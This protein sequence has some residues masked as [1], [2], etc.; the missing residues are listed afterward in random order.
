MG[1]AY[2]IGVDLGTTATKAA[3][4]QADGTLV[5]EALAEVPLYYPQ[6][7]CVE[8]DNDDFYRSAAYTVRQCM[9]NSGIAPSEVA[10][11]ALNSQMAGI[12][13]IDENF[14]PATRFDSWLDMRCQPYIEELEHHHSDLIIRLTG[15]PPTCD[16]GPKMMR[17]KEE[18]PERYRQIAKFVTPVGYVAGRMA[19]LKADQ[20]FIDYTFIHF[21]TLCDAQKGTWSP[22]LCSL[23][24]IDPD[25]LP[26][27]VAP[28][29]IIGEVTAD[30][31][32]E[33]GLAAGT[34]IAAGAGDSAA[35][36]LGAGM[37]RPGTLLDIA[38]TAAVRIVSLRMSSIVR[39][40]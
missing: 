16:H 39:Y 27:I 28:W 30:V 12:G 21:S 23:L 35:G 34:P 29:D 8:Q 9:Q 15:C 4:Y 26:R 13:T 17:W 2:V 33:F 24:G 32:R 1:R 11:I 38:G 6:P 36:A 31:A 19:G 20:A 37:V 22:E 3:L 14:H 25:K 7:D 10:A 40:S 18:Q 5:A